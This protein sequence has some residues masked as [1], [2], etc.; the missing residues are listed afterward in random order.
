M[1]CNHRGLRH[2]RHGGGEEREATERADAV[3]C[4]RV[5]RV[6]ALVVLYRHQHTMLLGC[7]KTVGAPQPEWRD[8][9]GVE[10]PSVNLTCQC[11]TRPTCGIQRAVLRQRLD[12]R[13]GNEHVQPRL[14]ARHGYVEVR[15]IR[16]EDGHHVPLPPMRPRQLHEVR[17]LDNVP[18]SYLRPR[19]KMTEVGL[20]SRSLARQRLC[21][22][23]CAS[24]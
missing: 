1:H 16:C 17:V 12:G 24:S 2:L 22:V 18:A 21:D 10:S 19:T 7:A 20:A 3:L 23:P 5:D 13:L 9:A 8:P 6:E 15:I 4:V 14:D 11:D